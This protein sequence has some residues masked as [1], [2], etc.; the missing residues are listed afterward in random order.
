MRLT[1]STAKPLLARYAIQGACESDPRVLEK[2]NEA[3]E[4]LMKMPQ[5]W[6]GKVQRFLFCSANSC[7]TL[8][9]EIETVEAA[10]VCNR[11]MKMRGPWYDVLESG[12]GSGN[13]CGGDNVVDRGD[14]YVSFV[15]LDEPRNIKVYTDVPEASGARILLQGFDENGNRVRTFDSVTNAYVDGEYVGLNNATPQV[16]TTVFS[17]LDGIVK[18]ETNGFIRLYA[19][20][21]GVVAVP[22][23]DVTTVEPWP[24]NSPLASEVN[25]VEDL[26]TGSY[27]WAGELLELS[28]L[29]GPAAN[30][31][32]DIGIESDGTNLVVSFMDAHDGSGSYLPVGGLFT[33]EDGVLTFLSYVDEGTFPNNFRLVINGFPNL[34]IGQDVRLRIRRFVTH[35][36]NSTVI[37]QSTASVSASTWLQ[38]EGTQSWVIELQGSQTGSWLDNAQAWRTNGEE[39]EIILDSATFTPYIPASTT[40]D[41]VLELEF[42][43]LDGL[44][45]LAQVE[46][47]IE[48]FPNQLANDF[49][50]IAFSIDRVV[51]EAVPATPDYLALM[52]I[53]HPDETNPSYRRYE[54][55][56]LRAGGSS[57]C[58]GSGDSED[59][60][61]KQVVVMAKLRYLPVKRATDFLVIEHIGA[62]KMMLLALNFE[63]KGDFDTAF[64]YETKAAEILAQEI[65]NHIGDSATANQPMQVQQDAWAASTIPNIL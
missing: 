59:T 54:I 15:D 12:P 18:P 40:A 57:C 39:V 58:G 63:E 21:A 16:S 60:T 14:G 4:R 52:A 49:Q 32:F 19:F 53:Y 62:L 30:R 38:G 11:P 56:Q 27:V 23:S 22:F 46:V 31:D 26:G 13:M 25:I 3:R 41:G 44:T 5:N 55:P 9:R 28:W 42:R 33:L 34:T 24:N 61:P 29:S 17:T 6:K 20:T 1:L 37:L 7:I 45:L 43:L 51:T 35:P 10:T 36:A 48:N 2:I 8:P 64:K 65:Q 50:N 47:T